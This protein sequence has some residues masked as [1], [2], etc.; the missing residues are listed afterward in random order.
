MVE[1]VAVVD[2]AATDEWFVGRP[3]LPS[4]EAITQPYDAILVTDLVSTQATFE[5][6]LAHCSSER[7]LVPRLLRI[8]PPE[9][10]PS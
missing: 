5:A 4:F 2:T 7:V 8:K 6:A 3:V 10:L 9:W 1:I